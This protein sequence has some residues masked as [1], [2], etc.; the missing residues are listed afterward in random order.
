MS[1]E[2]LTKKDWNEFRATGLFWYIN[3][4]LHLFGWAIV[5]NIDDDGKITD[6]FPARTIFRGFQAECNDEGF[7]K[8]TDYLK[9][10]I[11]ELQKEVNDN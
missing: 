1:K 3:F 5:F 9:E 4:T 10:N 7:K 2:P 11:D 8:V 6:V